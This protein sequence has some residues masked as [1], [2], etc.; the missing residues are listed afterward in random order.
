MVLVPHFS[1]LGAHLLNNWGCYITVA[2][3]LH[4]ALTHNFTYVDA[5]MGV[6]LLAFKIAI[7]VMDHAVFVLFDLP[8]IDLRCHWVHR[9]VRCRSV[10][11]HN[12]TFSTTADGVGLFRVTIF[13]DHLKRLFFT[14]FKFFEG[15][16]IVKSMIVKLYVVGVVI[17]AYFGSLIPQIAKLLGTV[18]LNDRWVR[19]LIIY[20][21]KSLNHFWNNIVAKVDV[22][23]L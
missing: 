7:P 5:Q 20:S 1:S 10:V 14:D 18:F 17:F 11:R 23:L 8:Q 19:L 2:S 6:L 15:T 12:V 13:I 9:T 4:C 22:G 16:V 21:I 3:L